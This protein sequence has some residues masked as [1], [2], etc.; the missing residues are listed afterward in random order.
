MR[1]S[2]GARGPRAVRC[3]TCDAG[4]GVAP[5]RYMAREPPLKVFRAACYAAL[6]RGDV[7]R[8]PIRLALSHH[9]ADP[10]HHPGG[11]RFTHRRHGEVPR[12]RGCR[13]PDPR[14]ARRP[15]AVGIE[16]E[17]RVDERPR[18]K[19]V[20]VGDTVADEDRGCEGGAVSAGNADLTGSGTR[21]QVSRPGRVPGVCVRRR[22]RAEVALVHAQ[23]GVDLLGVEDGQEPVGEMS[24][25]RT[26]HPTV[27]GFQPTDVQAR[28]GR[29]EADAPHPV[30][31]VG[32]LVAVVRVAVRAEVRVEHAAIFTPSRRSRVAGCGLRVAAE[33]ACRL[34][35]ALPLLAVTI[36]REAART[37]DPAKLD[38]RRPVETRADRCR[39]QSGGRLSGGATPDNRLINGASGPPQPR[40]AEGRETAVARR[41][42]RSNADFRCTSLADSR[43]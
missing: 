3:A 21:A 30:G 39:R 14:K 5:G 22:C 23:H 6:H 18:R 28:I 13:G 38:D 19:V 11:K 2:S 9:P 29:L 27:A 40:D 16:G 17:D 10:H 43:C 1:A 15:G 24:G 20:V 33:T 34:R 12:R 8:G 4:P 36:T 26:V 37:P 31:K 7:E 25:R 42:C 35:L 41:L 32:E